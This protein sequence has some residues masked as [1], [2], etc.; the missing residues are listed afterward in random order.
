MMLSTAKFGSVG[1]RCFATLA[2]NVNVNHP[3]IGIA[4]NILKLRRIAAATCESSLKA[5]LSDAVTI[6]QIAAQPELTKYEFRLLGSTT[7]TYHAPFV[8]SPHAWQNWS[9]ARITMHEMRKSINY[10]FF[11]GFV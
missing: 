4:K 2:D 11:L 7:K 8:K 9:W 1:R 5:A 10:G 3:K 6:E